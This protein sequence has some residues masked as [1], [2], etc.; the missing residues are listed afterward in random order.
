MASNWERSNEDLSGIS[1]Q[2]PISA[3]GWPLGNAS[4]RITVPGQVSSSAPGERLKYY[5]TAPIAQ[6]MSGGPIYDELH[7][8]I[9]VV[10]SGEKNNP[11]LT[12]FTG[13]PDAKDTLQQ[14]GIGCKDEPTEAVWSADFPHITLQPV[15]PNDGLPLRYCDC[16]SI[17]TIS[18]PP[19]W[20]DGT[21]HYAPSGAKMLVK[22]TCPGILAV[23]FAKDFSPS[24]IWWQQ[25]APGRKFAYSVLPPNRSVSA[26]MS[27]A[28]RESVRVWVN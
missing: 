23:L 5:M 22:N 9:G 25:P 7:N 21:L 3:V 17:E 6:G 10:S 11:T 1:S 16:G 14:A 8:V 4:P 26:D 27:L 15:N 20:P 2:E 28:I 19:S 24:P 13:L 18:L 12:F